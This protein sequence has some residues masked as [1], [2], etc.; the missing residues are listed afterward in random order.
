M[1][2]VLV[3]YGNKKHGLL[4]EYEDQ[5]YLAV[6]D[7]PV[8]VDSRVVGMHVCVWVLFFEQILRLFKCRSKYNKPG[9]WLL[10]ETWRVPSALNRAE[11]QHSGRTDL[12]QSFLKTLNPRALSE[13]RPVLIKVLQS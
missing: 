9:L 11:F 12:P 8:I 1:E 7:Y 13:G 2:Q 5:Q 6:E 10:K 4:G 3:A